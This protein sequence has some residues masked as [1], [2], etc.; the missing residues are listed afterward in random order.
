MTQMPTKTNA[1]WVRLHLERQSESSFMPPYMVGL[2]SNE[3][4]GAY[5]LT[6]V[7]EYRENEE[8]YTME[9]YIIDQHNHVSKTYV[10]RC[11][12]LGEKPPLDERPFN[13]EDGGLG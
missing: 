4:P 6:K 12:V 10:W 1:I 8:E 9:P 5:V 13:G 7:I 2:L 11:E 3:T